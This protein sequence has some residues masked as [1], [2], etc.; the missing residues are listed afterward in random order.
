ML[1]AESD[2]RSTAPIPQ[3]VIQCDTLIS[4]LKRLKHM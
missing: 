3:H 2:V 1:R 4:V